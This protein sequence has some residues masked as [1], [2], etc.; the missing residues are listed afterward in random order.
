MPTITVSA[1]R[2]EEV[3]AASNRQRVQAIR[4]VTAEAIAT[5]AGSQV[6]SVEKDV[7]TITLEHP[8]GEK[9]YHRPLKGS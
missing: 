5:R 1:V 9:I 6:T 2:A 4:I 7:D 3:G 8:C